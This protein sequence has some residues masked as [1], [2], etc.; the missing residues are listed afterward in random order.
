L[1][2]C[3]DIWHHRW[4]GEIRKPQAEVKRIWHRRNRYRYSNRAN[5]QESRSRLLIS[6]QKNGR[7]S[8]VK[9]S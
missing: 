1:K 5:L 6:Q 8:L 9:Q 2:N 7:D 3:K 4:P